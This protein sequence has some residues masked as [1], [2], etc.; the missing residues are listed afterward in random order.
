[1]EGQYGESVA[2][3]AVAV[4]VAIKDFV[5][6]RLREFLGSLNSRCTIRVPLMQ[7]PV[8]PGDRDLLRELTVANRSDLRRLFRRMRFSAGFDIVAAVCMVFLWAT[9]MSRTFHL[10][11]WVT[12]GVT[13]LVAA[14]LTPL[15]WRSAGRRYHRR[16]DKYDDIIKKAEERLRNL[17]SQCS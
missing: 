13:L 3:L 4:A 6:G 2:G 8:I 5:D 1:M 10:A 7:T 14:V 17:D 12:Y 16:F 15:I 9:E 11:A